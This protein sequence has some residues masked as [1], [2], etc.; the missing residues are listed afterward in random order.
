MSRL[1]KRKLIPVAVLIFLLL[2]YFQVHSL[3][4]STYSKI[5]I[6]SNG[7]KLKIEISPSSANLEVDS[8]YSY[9]MTFEAIEFSSDQSKFYSLSARLRFTNNSIMVKS[10]LICNIGDLSYIGSRIQTIIQ[11]A[12]PSAD[13]FSL[14]RGGSFLGQLEYIVYYSEQSIDDN[15]GEMM[16]NFRA[17]ETDQTIGWET[18]AQG[19]ITNP[20]LSLPPIVVIISITGILI[21]FA[22]SILIVIRESSKKK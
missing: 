14:D 13:E 17:Y 15:K 12:I 11:L 7:A 8:V 2:Q 10:D 20:L 18:I 22:S 21:V 6:Q 1:K 4:N 16:G 9:L 19:K 5:W 3:P